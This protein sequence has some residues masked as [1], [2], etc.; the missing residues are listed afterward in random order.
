MHSRRVVQAVMRLQE[1]YF[2]LKA[3]LRDPAADVAGITQEMDALRAALAAL[4]LAAL[5]DERQR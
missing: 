5:V 3:R 2:C 1:E 4:G